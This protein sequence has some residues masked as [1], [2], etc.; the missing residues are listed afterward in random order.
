M[1]NNPWANHISAKV[2]TLIAESKSITKTFKNSSIRG[3]IRE[4]FVKQLLEPLLPPDIGIGSGE[5][6]N[7][8]GKRSR[9]LDVVLYNKKRVPPTLVSGSDTGVFPWECVVS[10]IE[11]KSVLT[12][13][14]L[15]EAHVNANSVKDV[16]SNIEE[17]SG[18]ISGLKPLE[19]MFSYGPI[20][21]YV[22]AF[23]S[24]LPESTEVKEVSVGR[25]TPHLGQ[26]GRRLFRSFTSLSKKRN[27]LQK[28]TF[29][30]SSSEKKKETAKK[31]LHILGGED[32]FLS[33]EI[34]GVCVAGREWTH[35]HIHFDSKVFSRYSETPIRVA[36]KWNFHWQSYFNKGK[37]ENV[38]SL[39]AHLIELSYEMPQ[40]R[41]HY[42]IARYLHSRG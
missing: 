12:A 32:N 38:L 4:L 10:V 22:F 27:A 13:S 26:E 9:Q 2:E 25:M 1:P 35:G 6:I 30:E 34:N 24:G 5:I 42:N 41:E 29:D 23:G 33:Q 8:E 37:M 21:Y 17:P 14:T 15:K 18:T 7:H 3:A 31:Q 16:Y 11:V 28:I 36:D 39:L 20:P 19:N 40:C